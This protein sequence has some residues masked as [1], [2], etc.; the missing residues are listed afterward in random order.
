MK[1]L[2]YCPLFV[3]EMIIKMMFDPDFKPMSRVNS[4]IHSD[5]SEPRE[6]F[7]NCV[8]PNMTVKHIKDKR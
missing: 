1:K 8:S 6:L 3:E 7:V 2:P 5:F 4:E